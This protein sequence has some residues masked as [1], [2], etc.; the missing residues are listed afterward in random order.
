LTNEDVFRKRA[1]ELFLKLYGIVNDVEYRI[2]AEELNGG[3]VST[4]F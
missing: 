3:T 2:R 1:A 4:V